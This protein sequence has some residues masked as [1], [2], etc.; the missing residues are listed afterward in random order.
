MATLLI[1][2][3]ETLSAIDLRHKGARVIKC[4]HARMR[5]VHLGYLRSNDKASSLLPPLPSAAP[6]M[7]L[8]QDSSRL[9]F[10]F[11]VPLPVLVV[12]GYVSPSVTPLH[13]PS[14]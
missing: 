5:T 7:R 1:I 8:S 10:S 13:S 4:P 11:L 9:L 14:R 12:F 2:P 3:K 6:T